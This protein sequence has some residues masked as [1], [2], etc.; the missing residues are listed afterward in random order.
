MT[1]LV[2]H[3]YFCFTCS[4]MVDCFNQIAEDSECRVVVFSG[5][6]K[7]FTSGKDIKH[8]LETPYRI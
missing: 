1:E 8:Y 2:L 4:E 3:V 5:A 7:L 6:G